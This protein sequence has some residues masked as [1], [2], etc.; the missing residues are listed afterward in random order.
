MAYRI[1]NHVTH[2]EIDC[3]EKGEITGKLWL[4]GGGEPVVLKLSGNAWPDMAG[5]LLS[6]V[7]KSETFAPR[8][9]SPLQRLQE[10]AAGDMTA[11]RKVR[12]PAVPID[13]F[14]EMT[15][16]GEKPPERLANSLYLEWFT[17]A[18]GRVVFES[19]ECEITLSTPK[20][21]L[22]PEEEAQR[23]ADA[24]AGLDDFMGKLTEA[25]ESAEAKVPWHKE[26]WDEFDHEKLLRDSDA[27]TDKFGELMEK[28]M[29]HPDRD[30]IIARE[31][32]WDHIT[33]M[34]DEK[35]AQEKMGETGEGEVSDTSI[36]DALAAGAEGDW[37]S[38][39]YVEPEPDP[40]TEGKDWIRTEDGDIKH[41]LSD[42]AFRGAIGLWNRIKELGLKEDMDEDLADL[43]G[44]Y[45]TVGAKLA[46]ALDGLARDRNIGELAHNIARMKRGLTYLHS[47]Q[48]ALVKVG[49]KKLLPQEDL[50]RIRGELFAIREEMLRLMGEFRKGQ[51]D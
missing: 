28:Y 41:P 48:A 26:E 33:E 24:A 49:E 29:D 46:G 5:C 2:G 51:G 43:W 7:N 40:A 22:T 12:V 30:R 36:G 1:H 32:G 6:F 45:S 20:W 23:A 50:E 31:M 18:N 35:E 44:Q 9:D 17:E 19:A 21:R 16:R 42:R 47:A 27:R 4:H 37:S 10:G 38:D 11:S 3:R 8:S 13:E 25:I 39:D 34:L 15:M 14:C